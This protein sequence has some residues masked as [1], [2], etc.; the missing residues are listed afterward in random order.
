VRILGDRDAWGIGMIPLQGYPEM[1]LKTKEEQ[2]E[3]LM[4]PAIS[5]KTNDLP[6]CTAICMK[7]KVLTPNPA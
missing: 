4:H 1:L 2:S 3:E 5:M 6:Y 7:R